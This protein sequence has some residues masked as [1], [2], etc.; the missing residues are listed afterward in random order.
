MSVIEISSWTELNAVRGDISATA[1]YIQTRDLLDTDADYAGIGDSFV[2]LSRYVVNQLF[3]GK[4]NGQGFK[5]KGLR[6]NDTNNSA[7]SRGSGLFGGI[8]LNSRV[9]NIEFDDFVI[10]SRDGYSGPVG[11]TSSVGWS[12]LNIHVTNSSINAGAFNSTVNG[13]IIGHVEGGSSTTPAI[14]LCE[15][16]SVTNT[17]IGTTGASASSYNSGIIGYQQGG[18]VRG[19]AVRGS[20]IR[21]GNG[22]SGDNA[23]LGGISVVRG[24]NGL[25]EDCYV[26]GSTIVTGTTGSNTRAGGIITHVIT[27]TA[28]VR[29]CWVGVLTY[30]VATYRR[31]GVI[32]NEIAGGVATDCYYDSA[33]DVASDDGGA[34][35]KT[36][37]EMYQQAT[38]TNWDFD[39][40]WYIRE[41]EDYPRLRSIDFIS[42]PAIE[43]E[44]QAAA[45]SL[46][47][48]ASLTAGVISE[49]FS[50][51]VPAGIVISQ[52]PA[53]G[54]QVEYGSAVD[55]VVSLGVENATMPTIMGLDVD[56]AD[57]LLLSSML[58]TGVVSAVSVGVGEFYTVITQQYPPGTELA[59]GTAVNYTILVPAIDLAGFK[60][61]IGYDNILS[62]SDVTLTASSTAPGTFVDNIADGNTYDFW[63]SAE[64]VS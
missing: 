25:V 46:I 11:S 48:A 37:A 45:L 36:T 54:T 17:I 14:G 35:A 15:N 60:T 56:T 49:E 19:C 29:R 10:V 5:I 40:V 2:P 41:G 32:C 55:F 59:I 23:R 3:L 64:G 44:T 24:S 57:A 34:T 31:R 22:P 1:E 20:T 33:T 62:R 30:P 27:G 52:S 21:I 26:D 4:Y 13:G 47:A 43:G 6:I 51:T 18:T 12:V 8:G 61:V 38:Y 39:D 63:Q 53:A 42:A 28:N 50:N 7:S 9:E 16:C 58:T